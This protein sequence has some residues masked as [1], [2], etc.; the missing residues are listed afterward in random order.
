MTESK[1]EK[2]RKIEAEWTKPNFYLKVCL[3]EW[4]LILEWSEGIKWSLDWM[5]NEVQ[6]EWNPTPGMKAVVAEPNFGLIEPERKNDGERNRA[7]N[8]LN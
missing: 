6:T 5:I 2:K 3:S 4:Y 7:S 8:K 1:T